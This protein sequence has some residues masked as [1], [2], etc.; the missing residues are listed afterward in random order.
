MLYTHSTEKLIG[1]QGL[2]VKNI[3]EKE[4][5]IFIYS[6]MERKSHC[7][8]HCS[9]TTSTIHDYRTQH[10]KDIDAFGKQV[11]IILRKRRYR[12]PHCGKRFYE[13]NSFLPKFHRMTNRLA[14]FI[15]DKLRDTRSFTSVAK[16]L[17]LSVTTV[18]RVFDLVSYPKAKLDSAVSVDEFK[19][20]TNG[21]KYHCIL[22]DPI[23][24][25]ILDILPERSKS[26][27]TEYFREY[28]EERRSKVKYFV[29]DMWRTYADISSAFFP[30]ATQLIDRFHWVRQGIWAFENVRKEVQ[31]Q[32][33]PKIAIYFKRS[34]S[35][36]TKRFHTLNEEEKQ[37]V[38]TM[39]YYSEVIRDAYILK[40]MFLNIRCNKDAFS[41]VKEME[42][43]IKIAECCDIPQFKKCAKTMRNWY[44][45][46][47]NSFFSDITN[48]FTEG[49]NNKI[50]VLK[51]NAFGYQNFAR[52]RNRILHIFS[53]QNT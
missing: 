53:Q 4:N 14:T 43:W 44:P 38:N 52:F 19:G 40:E 21:E 3:E 5:T 28:P 24:K 16:E 32:L 42:R 8:P 27:L 20:D 6:E 34:K 2:I 11:M 39:L 48:G 30:N 23:T 17:H 29:S 51:R 31:K 10:I 25:I 33:D 50:K 18:I 45:G 26:Y 7:C 46:I 1:L 15:I 36:L 12:C 37:K 47:I 41:A 22:T 13:N 9:T 35:L 49:C